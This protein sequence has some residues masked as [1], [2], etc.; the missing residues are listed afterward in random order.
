MFFSNYFIVLCDVICTC[1]TFIL[2]INLMHL[3]AGVDNSDKVE[4]RTV[5][6]TKTCNHNVLYP[7][8]SSVIIVFCFVTVVSHS[9]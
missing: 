5:V 3:H 7:T 1:L 8:L 2:L 9:S 4:H 6:L